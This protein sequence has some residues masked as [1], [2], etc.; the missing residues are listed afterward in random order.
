VPAVRLPARQRELHASQLGPALHIP[1]GACSVGRRV[2]VLSA[3]M[4]RS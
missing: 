4:W 2:G 1:R 3:G